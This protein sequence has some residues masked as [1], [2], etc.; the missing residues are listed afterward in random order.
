MT[1]AQDTPRRPSDALAAAI[2]ATE[3]P[4]GNGYRSDTY[5][6]RLLM[7]LRRLGWDVTR[8]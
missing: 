3:R 7:A 1:A 5:E 2:E 8:R 6:V 4:I